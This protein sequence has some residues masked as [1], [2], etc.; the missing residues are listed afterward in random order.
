[1]KK[2]KNYFCIVLSLL[3]V[4]ICPVFSVSAYENESAI[5]DEFVK[6]WMNGHYT[7]VENYEELYY[8]EDNNGNADWVLIY[9]TTYG[10][11]DVMIHRQLGN[12]VIEQTEGYIPFEI[13]YAVYDINKNEFYDILDVWE[14]GKFENLPEAFEF[15]FYKKNPDI[16]NKPGDVN[17]DNVLDVLDSVE[18]QKNSVDKIQFTD[19]QKKIGDYNKDGSCDVLDAVEIQKAVVAN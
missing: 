17:G 9:V 8:H 13:G 14:S 3:F 2:A 16:Q 15:V 5:K 12:I 6:T 4:C 1:M 18:I 11:T 19:A 10:G 7:S